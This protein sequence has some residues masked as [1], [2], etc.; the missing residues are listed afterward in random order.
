[1]T[2]DQITMRLKTLIGE[3]FSSRIILVSAP[4]SNL[5]KFI[6]NT[7]ELCSII[8]S[9]ADITSY[10]KEFA[11]AISESRNTFKLPR[12]ANRIVTLV[13]G[14]LYAFDTQLYSIVEFISKRFPG[15]NNHQS[16]LQ[17]CNS[18][19]NPYHTALVELLAAKAKP[20]APSARGDTIIRHFPEKARDEALAWIKLLTSTVTADN[21]IYDERLRQEYILLLRAMA[22]VLDDTETTLIRAIWIGIRNTFATYPNGT[23]AVNEL[24]DLLYNYEVIN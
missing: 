7:P 18:V 1:M 14:L 19:L 23:R 21:D 12:E 2:K 11:L 6:T 5:L 3:F 10:D 24:G 15:I 13:T 22:R 9:A 8:Y 20:K 17:F 16:Y 4:I